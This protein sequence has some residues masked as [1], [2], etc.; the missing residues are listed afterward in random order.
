V[1][2]R[3]RRR[4]PERGEIDEAPSVGRP[5]RVVVAFDPRRIA[6][7]LRQVPLHA[8]SSAPR[9]ASTFRRRALADARRDHVE[10]GLPL[11][12]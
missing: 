2:A 12:V 6:D 8:G 9:I 10:L 5:Q 3:D 1:P 7:P 11:A 4:E